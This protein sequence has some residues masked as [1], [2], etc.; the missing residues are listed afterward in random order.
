MVLNRLVIQFHACGGLRFS[1]F[2]VLFC[3]PMK[4]RVTEIIKTMKEMAAGPHCPPIRHATSTTGE[5]MAARPSG[6]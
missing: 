3:A 1:I 4:I 6:I 2:S 5:K